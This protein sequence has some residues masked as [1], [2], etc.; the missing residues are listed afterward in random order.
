[1]SWSV[2]GN[3][4]SQKVAAAVE[5]QFAAMTIPCPEPEETIKQ[6][7]RALL[8]QALAGNNPSR[9]LEVSAW[10]SQSN[11]AATETSPAHVSNSLHINI[12]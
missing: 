4:D 6:A 7:V 8:A 1:M 5:A 3:G 2:G 12:T 11:V 9:L 10:G